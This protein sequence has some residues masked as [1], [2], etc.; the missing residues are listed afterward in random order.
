[1]VNDVHIRAEPDTGAA[2]NVMDEYHYS[3][4][5][6]RSEYD[7]ELLTSQSK[8]RTLPN[9]LPVK[10]EFS[11]I[12]KTQT[13]GKRTKFLVIKGRMNSPLI[14]KNALIELCMQ[15]ITEDGS[16]AMEND[17]RIPGEISSIH[18]VDKNSMSS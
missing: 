3:V 18:A 9:D 14:S 6:H 8:L 15:Q 16:F 4:L 12:L 17:M 5:Q 2:V 1:M 11:A 7:M 10:E 13:C